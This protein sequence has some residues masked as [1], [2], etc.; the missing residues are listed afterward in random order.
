MS[1]AIVSKN[2]SLMFSDGIPGKKAYSLYS[3][4]EEIIKF[5]Y[6]NYQ[7]ANKF[8]R[9]I[10]GSIKPRYLFIHQNCAMFV[11]STKISSIKNQ[12]VTKITLTTVFRNVMESSIKF[13]HN[14]NFVSVEFIVAAHESMLSVKIDV[15]DHFILH[16]HDLFKPFGEWP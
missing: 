11:W 15:R 8:V 2:L 4:K 1:M 3:K 14:N 16:F 10:R 13:T 7:S 9:K 12:N 5:C 6:Q